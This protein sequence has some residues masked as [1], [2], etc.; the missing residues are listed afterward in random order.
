MPSCLAASGGRSSM[1]CAAIVATCAVTAPSARTA[2][3]SDPPPPLPF[4]YSG[5]NDAPVGLRGDAPSC[6]PWPVVRRCCKVLLVYVFLPCHAAPDGDAAMATA[7]LVLPLKGSARFDSA[8]RAGTATSSLPM[9]S[10]ASSSHSSYWLAT[11]CAASGV[12]RL[13]RYAACSASR[14]MGAVPDPV[15]AVKA[16]L[17][18]SIEISDDTTAG[19]TPLPTG[20]SGELRSTGVRSNV[21]GAG[22]GNGGKCS[23]V[24]RL[25][26]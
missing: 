22:R 4:P 24:L 8:G 19:E 2:S 25:S 12:G 14:W 6:A 16:I 5:L 10:H 17:G 18:V 1:H 13:L 9:T 3:A 26:A 20:D 7:G 23:R 11:N 21:S 15:K